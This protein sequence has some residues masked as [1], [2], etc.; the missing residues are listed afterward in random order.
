MLA[1]IGVVFCELQA[2]Q[3]QGSTCDNQKAGSALVCP[4]RALEIGNEYGGSLL[5]GWQREHQGFGRAT[6]SSIEG[7]T[8][9]PQRGS[10]AVATGSH[11]LIK[12]G[13]DIAGHQ[14]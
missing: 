13:V 8:L 1:H 14:K 11:L 4:A 5:A 6:F 3:L 7:E 9:K 2:N 10:S 12:V